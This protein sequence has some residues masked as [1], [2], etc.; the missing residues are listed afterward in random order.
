MEKKVIGY[1]QDSNQAGQAANELK[2]KGFKEISL[3]GND[4]G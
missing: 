3:L 2:T 1:F 4:K